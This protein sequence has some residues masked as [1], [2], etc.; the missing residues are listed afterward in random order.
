[1]ESDTG[2]EAFS[3]VE[4]LGLHANAMF[5]HLLEGSGPMARFVLDPSRLSARAL[6]S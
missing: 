5:F 3:L 6:P 2:S 4:Q 1:M